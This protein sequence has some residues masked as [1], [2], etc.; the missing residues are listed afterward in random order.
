MLGEAVLV[1]QANRGRV[2]GLDG[3]GGCRASALGQPLQPREQERPPGSARGVGRIDAEDVDLAIGR[4]GF[5]FDPVVADD[6]SVQVPGH[7]EVVRFE[8]RLGLSRAQVVDGQPTLLRMRF[9]DPCI[10]LDPLDCILV[11]EGTDRHPVP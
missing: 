6:A 10:Q 8:P 7:E 11:A 2:V 4:I 1:V 5:H 9:E 3:H